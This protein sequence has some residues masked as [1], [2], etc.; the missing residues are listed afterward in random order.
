MRLFIAVRFLGEVKTGLRKTI[1]MLK[2]QTVS[3]NFTRPEN[4]HLT[5]AFI[6]E[7]NEIGAII[8]VIDGIA[9]PIF[10]LNI[11]GFGHFGSLYWVGIEKNPALMRLV[12]HLQ[13]GLRGSGINIEERA[14]NPHITIAREV[15]L[16]GPLNV[17]VPRMRMTVDRIS[18]M[19]S[20][21]LAGKI[22]YS[23]IYGKKLNNILFER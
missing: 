4:L 11:G 3:G 13:Y 22:A 12:H 9:Q 1:N 5:L 2:G 8:K 19:K 7:S 17:D 20:E 14:Y 6:G 18:L 21:R 15:R 23:E 16:K 10:E